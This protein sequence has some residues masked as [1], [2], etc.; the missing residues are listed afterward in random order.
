MLIRKKIASAHE[1]KARRLRGSRRAATPQVA[2]ERLD[3]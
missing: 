2:R 1:A 3:H